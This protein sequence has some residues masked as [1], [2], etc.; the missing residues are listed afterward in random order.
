[1]AAAADWVRQ[2]ARLAESMAVVVRAEAGR[3]WCPRRTRSTWRL[4]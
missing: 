3:P 4:P 1:M 2:A